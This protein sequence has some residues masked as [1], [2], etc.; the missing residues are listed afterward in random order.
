MKLPA[1]NDLILFFLPIA[2]L[3]I[4]LEIS[5][6]KILKKDNYTL[7]GFF[8]NFNI[9]VGEMLCRVFTLVLYAGL[10]Q[11]IYRH[12]LFQW[13]NS[14]PQIV[15][16]YI[17]IDFI[18]YWFHRW[19]HQFNILWAI[20]LVHHSSHD[21]NLTTSGRTPW[22]KSLS[23]FP[24]YLIFALMG[25]DLSFFLTVAL[26][27]HL[28]Q[29]WVHTNFLSHRRWLDYIIVN[30]SFHR[31]HHGTEKKYININY[32][33]V[34][35]IWDHLF[36]TY[37]PEEEL[38]TYGLNQP[39]NINRPIF[40]NLFYFIFLYHV[41]STSKVWMNRFRIFFKTPGWR[42]N[43]V[44]NEA[45]TAHWNKLIG[46][47]NLKVKINPNA[48]WK[49]WTAFIII[50]MLTGAFFILLKHQ[51][52]LILAGIMIATLALMEIQGKW[53]DNGLIQENL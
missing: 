40:H 14:I 17:V 1:A 6:S 25:I 32:A 18:H 35:P 21:F 7:I 22:L 37:H 24:I 5:L 51:N 46:P 13:K 16:L 49:V 11:Y 27:T 20:H 31:A 4:I 10:Y 42:P 33:E 50:Y 39:T 3:G 9:T 28:S 47:V 53:I 30:P 23:I 19:S 34:L 12:H 29:F 2:Y 38:P 36:R 41:G 44:S 15:L 43:D 52:Y 48:R 26:F 8:Q 45:V